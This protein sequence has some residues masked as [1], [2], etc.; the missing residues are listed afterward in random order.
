M[1]LEQTEL[2]EVVPFHI[3]L[4]NNLQS[5]NIN[6][7]YFPREKAFPQGSHQASWG[8]PEMEAN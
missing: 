3:R 5:I 4:T 2:M 7:V 6:S 8:I 1:G